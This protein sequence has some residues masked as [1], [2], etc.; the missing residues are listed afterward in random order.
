MKEGKAGNGLIQEQVMKEY[1][2]D[3][4]LMSQTTLHQSFQRKIPMQRLKGL[5]PVLQ[6]MRSKTLPLAT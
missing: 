5:T 4:G 2:L 3:T 6:P 1:G